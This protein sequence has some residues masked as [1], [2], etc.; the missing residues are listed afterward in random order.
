MTWQPTFSPSLYPNGRSQ[1]ISAISGYIAFKGKWQIFSCTTTHAHSTLWCTILPHG[2]L[3][4]A[5]PIFGSP[6]ASCP[7]LMLTHLSQFTSFSFVQIP[8]HF[9][10]ILSINQHVP[11]LFQ[12][13]ACAVNPCS[14]ICFKSMSPFHH[15]LYTTNTLFLSFILSINR[16][17][18]VIKCDKP[19]GSLSLAYFIFTFLIVHLVCTPVFKDPHSTLYPTCYNS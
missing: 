3:H 6:W 15:F 13:G 4:M 7:H 17:S 10:L 5:Y 14:I 11:F 2:P 9:H 18:C 12:P 19:K 8:S 1:C 16:L